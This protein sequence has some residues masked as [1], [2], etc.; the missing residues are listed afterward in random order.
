M[1]LRMDYLIVHSVEIDGIIFELLKDALDESSSKLF[2]EGEIAH[3]INRTGYTTRASESPEWVSSLKIDLEIEEVDK[4]AIIESFHQRLLLGEDDGILHVTKLFD[5]DL[6][7]KLAQYAS[8][9]FDLEMKIRE[10][11]SIIFLDTYGA[12]DGYGFLKDSSQ[13]MMKN[14]APGAD[15]L[16]ANLENELFYLLFNQYSVLNERASI[17]NTKSLISIMSRATD[18]NSL[19]AE[20]LRRPI[21]KPLYVDFLAGL[22]QLVDPIEKVRNCVAHNRSI[23]KRKAENYST[24]KENLEVHIEEFLMEITEVEL[25]LY[26]KHALDYLRR[27]LS[28]SEWDY[29][30]KTVTLYEDDDPRISTTCGTPEEFISELTQIAE[31]E[32]YGVIPYEGGHPVWEF[33][34]TDTALSA[35]AEYEDEL[36]EMG[37]D[38]EI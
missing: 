12:A 19:R 38:D 32:G 1:N 13:S 36:K 18:F 26:E 29:K 34:G 5:S 25:A 10:V 4:N 37:W 20:L 23:S 22:Q 15:D 9:L 17:S 35:L 27:I 21:S 16:R 24:A 7:H 28:E 14:N 31:R 11:L 8:E 6:K 33:D 2:D 30:E 3:A